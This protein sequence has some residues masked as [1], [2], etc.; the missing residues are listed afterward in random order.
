MLLDPVKAISEHAGVRDGKPAPARDKR[1][2]HP[3]EPRSGVSKDGGIRAS[4]FETAL[5]ASSP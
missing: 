5:R 4:W 2:P 3:E 1:D